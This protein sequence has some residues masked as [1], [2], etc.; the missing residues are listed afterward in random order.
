MIS[1]LLPSRPAPGGTPED[2]HG[3]LSEPAAAGPSPAS[4]TMAWFKN[5]KPNHGM[6]Q[7][8]QAKHGMVHTF[9]SP[10]VLACVCVRARESLATKETSSSSYSKVNSSSSYLK[11]NNS[12]S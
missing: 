4:Q 7:E 8:S 1:S 2:R 5:R 11:I 9:G 10:V 12:S 3:A 6:V